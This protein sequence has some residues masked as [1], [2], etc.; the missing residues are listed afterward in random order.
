MAIEDGQFRTDGHTIEPCCSDML[1]LITHHVILREGKV[2]FKFT[3]RGYSKDFNERDMIA[4]P[5]CGA[6]LKYVKYLGKGD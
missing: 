3:T 1:L 6:K 5:I 4:C 2:I